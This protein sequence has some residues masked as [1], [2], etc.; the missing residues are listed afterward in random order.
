M[1]RATVVAR[2][3]VWPPVA[4]VARGI[5]V[6]RQR[7]YKWRRRAHAADRDRPT[8]SRGSATGPL[9]TAPSLLHRVPPFRRHH[10]LQRFWQCWSSRRIAQYCTLPVSTVVTEPRRQGLNR[11]RRLEPSRLVRRN[12][13][14]R[15]G[16]L[17]HLDINR[18]AIASRTV[19]G[20]GGRE[21]AGGSSVWLSTT[22]PGSPKRECSQTRE[23]RLWLASSRAPW[24][25]TPHEA[26][27]CSGSRPT[28]RLSL[29]TVCPRS[30]AA[31]RQPF[32][33]AA[34]TALDQRQ[35]VA[36]YTDATHRMS[37]RDRLWALMLTDPGPHPLSVPPQLRRTPKRP[38]RPRTSRLPAVL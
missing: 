38:S 2:V 6:S 35:S 7:V 10:I 14:S 28:M 21:S 32:F 25:G 27:W 29:G 37:V 1:A 9:L 15:P 18:S 12:E 19:D 13:K 20:G 26:S 31:G 23:A 3:R 16:D 8:G 33:H 5:G 34:V 4:E 24:P 30:P 36:R 17:V 11:L 22:T